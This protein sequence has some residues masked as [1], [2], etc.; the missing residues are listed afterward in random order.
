MHEYQFL[1]DIG[2]NCVFKDCVKITTNFSVKK[3]W[4]DIF[5]YFLCC[6]TRGI[7]NW[8]HSNDLSKILNCN[9][10]KSYVNNYYVNSYEYDY[11]NVNENEIWF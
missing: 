10:C 6:S 7:G 8:L 4:C 2:K 3:K 11:V 1:A 9:K 5:A